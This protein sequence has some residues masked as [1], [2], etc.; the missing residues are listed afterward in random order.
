MCGR[1]CLKHKKAEI[2][3]SIDSL[4][5]PFE[6][7]EQY[8]LAPTQNILTISDE[9]NGRQVVARKWGLIPH[10]S[11]DPDGVKNTFNAR[12]E[13]AAEKAS[14]RSALRHHRC[15]IPVTGYYEWTTLGK[16]KQPYFI[17][18]ND[19]A[20]LLL[21]GI[22]DEW[23]HSDRL[24]QSC[25]ILTTESNNELKNIHHRMPIFLHK[26]QIDEW[27]SPEIQNPIRQIKWLHDKN[28]ENISFHPVSSLVN[29]VKN[30][31]PE[32][33]A[34]HTIQRAPTQIEFDF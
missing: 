4:E 16:Q 10:W 7:P 20:P 30:H 5:L 17:Y 13:S 15:I 34:P 28:T 1:I 22:W 14:F 27:L 18:K 23:D 31:G 32:L 8:N 21:A 29:S 33:I 25:S 12:I 2:E 24:I 9:Y 3:E 26:N 11:K 6:V 19:N